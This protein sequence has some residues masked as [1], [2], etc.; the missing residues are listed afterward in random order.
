MINPDSPGNLG[1]IKL[2]IPIQVGLLG[3]VLSAGFTFLF[4][5][6]SE[7]DRQTLTFLATALGTSAGVGSAFYVG[8]SIRLNAAS[9]RLDIT[10]S[11][12][13]R[14][15]DPSFDPVRKAA[16]KIHEMLDTNQPSRNSDIIQNALD[17]DLD[18]KLNLLDALNF[19]EEMALCVR[20]DIIDEGTAYKY[21]RSIVLTY[22]STFSIWIAKL[23][24]DKG[25]DMLF[26]NLTDLCDTWKK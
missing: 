1:K 22:C 14:W 16:Y 17:A 4:H 11:Y 2:T 25:N 6:S 10:T 8:Q 26:R 23:R 12:I 13:S 7:K 9:Q 15:S 20:L 5:S 19:L 18:L 24:S 3:V 21:Y